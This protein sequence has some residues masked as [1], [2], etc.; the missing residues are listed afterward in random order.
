MKRSVAKGENYADFL[1]VFSGPC[2]EGEKLVCAGFV[3]LRIFVASRI[4]KSRIPYGPHAP[5]QTAARFS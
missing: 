1:I 2:E 5:F 3:Y 4:F